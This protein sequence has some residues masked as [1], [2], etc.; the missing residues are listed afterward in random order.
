MDVSKRDI[1]QMN[2]EHQVILMQYARVQARCNELL[3]QRMAEIDVLRAQAM[4]QQAAI[5]K[6]DTALAWEREDR[7]AMEAAIPGL[8]RRL[9]LSQRVRAL[10]ERLRD[11]LRERT[12]WQLSFND[13]LDAPEA[14]SSHWSNIADTSVSTFLPLNALASEEASFAAAD[15]VICQTGC[16]SHGAYWRIEDHCKRTGKTCLMVEQPESLRIVRFEALVGPKRDDVST[17]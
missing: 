3:R 7:A 16:L 10:S 13:Q 6:R 17:E 8:P 11:L 9:A 1:E 2:S 15:L 12:R 4:R 14:G 5:I